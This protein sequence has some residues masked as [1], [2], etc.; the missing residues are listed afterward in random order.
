MVGSCIDL[1]GFECEILNFVSYMNKDI[2]DIEEKSK[3]FG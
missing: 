1:F 2:L 3:R